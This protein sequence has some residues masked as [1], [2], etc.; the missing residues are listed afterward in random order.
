[1]KANQFKNRKKQ[2]PIS[3]YMTNPIVVIIIFAILVG[4]FIPTQPVLT[5][6]IGIPPTEQNVI[7]IKERLPYLQFLYYQHY[8]TKEVLGNVVVNITIRNSLNQITWNDTYYLPLGN[9]IVKTFQPISTTD[10]VI[11]E[12][13]QYSF[14]KAILIEW[15]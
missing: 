7:I 11:I 9:Y 5:L 8:S 14:R 15:A 2:Q 3:E 13:P 4:M 1:M 12:I 6:G 10:I